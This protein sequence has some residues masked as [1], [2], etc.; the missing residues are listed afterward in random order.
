MSSIH[1]NTTSHW[2][3]PLPYKN[4]CLPFQ[5][6]QWRFLPP[7]RTWDFSNHTSSAPWLLPFRPRWAFSRITSWLVCPSSVVGDSYHNRLCSYCPY[8]R[9]IWL[10]W[11]IGSVPIRYTN[12]YIVSPYIFQWGIMPH[13]AHHWHELLLTDNPYRSSISGSADDKS[14][15]QHVPDRTTVQTLDLGVNAVYFRAYQTSQLIV[16]ICSML[17]TVTGSLFW[18]LQCRVSLWFLWDIPNDNSGWFIRV[19]SLG[20]FCV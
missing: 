6:V 11:V 18:P 16:T 7:L 10:W 4:V 2:Q 12:V 1:A 3:A 15:V 14:S 13:A 5:T 9:R 17:I 20:M 19:L 8:R